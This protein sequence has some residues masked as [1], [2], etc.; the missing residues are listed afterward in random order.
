MLSRTLTN[1]MLWV[2]GTLILPVGLGLLIAV[3]SWNAKAG[4]IFR[5]AFLI[6]YA[7]SGTAIATVWQ[8]MLV[9]DGAL[10]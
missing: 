4:S 5:L 3:L 10:E 6:P 8:F 7:L 9:R 1:T 2:I